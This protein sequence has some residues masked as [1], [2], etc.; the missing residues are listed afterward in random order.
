MSH[1]VR[2]YWPW[3]TACLALQ[4]FAPAPAH[5]QDIEAVLPA[6]ASR[7]AWAVGAGWWHYSEPDMKLEGP[8]LTLH[9]RYDGKRAGWPDRVEAEL[10]AASLHYSSRNSGSL[11]QV[12]MLRGQASSLWQLNAPGRLPLLRLL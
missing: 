5:A 4:T 12:P 6:Q 10:G 1:S 3:L 8:Q 11:S 2:L 9:G 7:I